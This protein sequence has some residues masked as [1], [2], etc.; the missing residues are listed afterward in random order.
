MFHANSIRL[1][2]CR[3]RAGFDQA[4]L[5]N[6]VGRNIHSFIGIETGR[7]LPDTQS[8]IAYEVLFDIPASSLLPDTR[9]NVCRITYER[10]QKLLKRC[11]ASPSR[12][13]RSKV[14]FLENLCHRLDGSAA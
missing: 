2:A 10:A 1:R 6:L 12:H 14:E 8:L 9:A 4:E 13:T 3:K 7:F 5:A 11:K